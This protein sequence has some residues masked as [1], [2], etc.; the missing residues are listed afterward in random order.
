M[1]EDEFSL[2]PDQALRLAVATALLHA[3]ISSALPAPDGSTKK[4][5]VSHAYE[6]AD[7]LIAKA[8]EKP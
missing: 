1:P 4:T 8:K 2:T 5:L 6:Y 3:T 7:Q